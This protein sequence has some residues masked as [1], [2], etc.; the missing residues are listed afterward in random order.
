MLRTRILREHGKLLLMFAALIVLAVFLFD[1]VSLPGAASW[2]ALAY[3][4]IL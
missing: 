4:L 2:G 3:R 1:E